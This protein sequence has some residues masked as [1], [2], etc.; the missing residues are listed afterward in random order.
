MPGLLSDDVLDHY[1]F[2]CPSRSGFTDASL[3]F[4]AQ[5]ACGK[6]EIDVKLRRALLRRYTVMKTFILENDVCTGEM[7]LIEHTPFAGRVLRSFWPF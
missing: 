6:A 7:L 1:N 4:S 5:Q 2:R 3:K